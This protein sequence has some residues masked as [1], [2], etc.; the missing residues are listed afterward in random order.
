MRDYYEF[1]FTVAENTDKMALVVKN[2]V[3]KLEKVMEE[4]DRDIQRNQKSKSVKAGDYNKLREENADKLG[5]QKLVDIIHWTQERN[6][7]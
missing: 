2:Y 3:E 4:L 5:I 7:K 1:I 6:K